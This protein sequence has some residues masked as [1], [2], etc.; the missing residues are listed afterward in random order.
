MRMTWRIMTMT[1]MTN[2]WNNL[3]FTD[4]FPDYDTFKDEFLRIP[5]YQS[6][7][8]DSAETLYYLLYGRYGNSTII[9]FDL[10]QFKFKLFSIIFQ[11]GPSW[12]KRLDIQK[13]VR[14]LTED[15]LL[16]NGKVIS[17]LAQNPQTLPGTGSDEEL[18]YINQQSVSKQKKSK[19]EAYA[20]QWEMIANDVTEDFIVRFEVLF[21]KVV[22]PVNPLLYATEEEDYE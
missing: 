19:L 16:S 21:K 15:E 22:T 13:K 7:T 9:N 18:S 2:Q 1:T 5:F 10:N 8:T 11:Y 4:V 17:N 3:K 20:L 12:E 14:N 6:I